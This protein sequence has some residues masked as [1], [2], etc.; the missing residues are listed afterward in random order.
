MDNIPNNNNQ[1]LKANINKNDDIN[2]SIYNEELDFTIN[3]EINT[4]IELFVTN[5]KSKIR[6]LIKRKIYKFFNQI[7][8]RI[9]KKKSI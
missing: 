1:H 6:N 9:T 7:T 4:D 3:N 5:K 2:K 8:S